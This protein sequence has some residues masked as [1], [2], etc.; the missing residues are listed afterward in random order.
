MRLRVF[1]SA[2]RLP[3]WRN[4]AADHLASGL[5]NAVLSL[6]SPYAR[7]I[8]CPIYRK[9]ISSL[10]RSPPS[11]V[12]ETK[13]FLMGNGAIALGDNLAPLPWHFTVNLDVKD[14][15]PTSVLI[16]PRQRERLRVLERCYKEYV[17]ISV[18]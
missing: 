14:H 2:L 7:P 5:L 13:F 10:D 9:V 17:I 1:F 15:H 11:W 6:S 16:H 12:R 3:P 8:S 4:V 18:A